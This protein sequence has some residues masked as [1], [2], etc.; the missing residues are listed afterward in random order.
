MEKNK[1]VPGFELATYR[2]AHQKQASTLLYTCVACFFLLV[3]MLPF[4]VGTYLV[5][6]AWS[7]VLY[8]KCVP[9]IILSS[10][11][12]KIKTG[13]TTK[14]SWVSNSRTFTGL[15][16]GFNPCAT[17]AWTWQHHSRYLSVHRRTPTPLLDAVAS[18][19]R[20]T[21]NARSCSPPTTWILGAYPPSSK[22]SARRRC[23]LRDFSS[24]C[25]TKSI[26]KK[27]T[28]GSLPPAVPLAITPTFSPW[29]HTSDDGYIHQLS[30]VLA[31]ATVVS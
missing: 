10:R 8:C 30:L 23:S 6:V 27:G 18:G 20:R 25:T 29:T 22:A 13:N 14:R 26:A 5:C 16:D 7:C 17:P 3:G 4:V 1:G 21:I 11:V 2:H 28:T 24:R 31:T 15:S 19:A 12:R 9:V